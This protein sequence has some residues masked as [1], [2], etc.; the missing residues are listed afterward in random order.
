[1]ATYKQIIGLNVEAKSSDPT[2]A[3]EGQ[4]WY[5]TTT[6]ALKG[7]AATSVGAW[8]SG[9][10]LNTP[11]RALGSAGIQTAA[12]AFSGDNGSNPVTNVESYNGT[13]W[14]ETTDV[15]T[16]RGF[17]GSSGKL[18]TAALLFGGTEPAY[19]AKT[20]NWNGSAWTEVADLST[21]RNAIASGLG[22]NTSAL[23][24]G[25]QGSSGQLSV[26]ES[27]NGTSWTEVG[28]SLIHI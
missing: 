28:L 18:Y 13:S 19:S 24:T 27:W 1:M 6:G 20:E 26:N 9:G 5:N 11:R 3:V 10:N 15:N 16:A 23:A 7:A 2:Y 22:T 14:T 21:A 8:A 17:A 12:L 25:G 4:V